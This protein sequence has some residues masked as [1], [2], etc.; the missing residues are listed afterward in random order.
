MLAKQT[1]A[2][3]NQGMGVLPLGSLT[4][5]NLKGLPQPKKGK[6]KSENRSQRS[7]FSTMST[8]SMVKMMDNPVHFAGLDVYELTR[9]ARGKSSSE[10]KKQ[11][12]SAQGQGHAG[13]DGVQ[14]IMEEEEHW[15]ESTG[16]SV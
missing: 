7:F 6:T 16:P 8:R 5:S 1:I 10:K 11:R 14:P 2:I 13:D 12:N 15:E 9:Q 3:S 4:A